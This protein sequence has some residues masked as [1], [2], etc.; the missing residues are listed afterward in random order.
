ML[1]HFQITLN[2]EQTNSGFE[3][4]FVSH[5]LERTHCHQVGATPGSFIL[6]R[7]VYEC[8]CSKTFCMPWKLRQVDFTSIHLFPIPFKMRSL[9]VT[10]GVYSD[11]FDQAFLTWSC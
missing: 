8:I 6:S 10:V 2:A 3:I 4:M 11:S 9:L 7:E 5:Y 1:H